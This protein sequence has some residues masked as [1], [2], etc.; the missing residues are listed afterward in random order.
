MAEHDQREA[1]LAYA[2]HFRAFKAAVSALGEQ[3]Y[4]LLHDPDR[5]AR[6]VQV[7]DRLEALAEAARAFDG[8]ASPSVTPIR[9]TRAGKDKE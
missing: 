6:M 9:R 8:E 1:R 2:G 4:N 5:Q 7:A 3:P